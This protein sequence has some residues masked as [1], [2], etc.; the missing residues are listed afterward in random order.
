MDFYHKDIK[1]V[2]TVF[3][4]NLNTDTESFWKDIEIFDENEYYNFSIRLINIVMYTM[5][6][7]ILIFV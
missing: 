6:I 3:L 1:S 2:D 7:C 5:V 4:Y